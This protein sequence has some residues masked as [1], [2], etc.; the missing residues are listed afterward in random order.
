MIDYGTVFANL[1]GIW[2]NY[3]GKNVTAPGAGDGTEW[4]AAFVSDVWGRVQALMDRA[5]LSPDGVT[6]AVGT[7][8]ILDALSLGY[9]IGAGCGVTWWK[10]L[11]PSVTG[12]RV[13][14]LQ[15]QVI[16]ISGYTDL[17]DATYVGDANNATAAAFYKTSD[18]GGTTRSTSGS[19]FVLPDTRECALVGVGTRAAGVTAHD[20]YT[21]GQMKDDQVQGHKHQ[22]TITEVHAQAAAFGTGGSVIGE[23]TFGTNTNN[24]ELTDVPYTDG[25]NGTPRTGTTTHGKQVGTDHGICY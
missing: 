18:A 23:R 19:Y 17:V 7:A 8:Q 4:I 13:L 15:G 12:D 20:T 9:G 1:T 21:K 3:A 2:P 10:N 11:S 14:L 6:E 16:A 24:S 5:S 22:T 25:P